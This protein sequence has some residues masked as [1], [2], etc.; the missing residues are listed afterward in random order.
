MAWKSS[1]PAARGKVIVGY[2]SIG[3]PRWRSAQKP[4]D[5]LMEQV[6][7]DPSGCH[8]WTGHTNQAGYGAVSINGQR[9]YAHRLAYEL[10]VGP[11]PE[12]LHID[13]TCHTN[14]ESCL[15]GPSCPHRACVNP[16]HLE[17]VTPAENTRRGAPARRTHCPQGHEYTPDNTQR[18]ARKGGKR[19]CKTCNRERSRATLA[20]RTHCYN[21]HE[22]TPD[23]LMIRSDGVRWCRTCRKAFADA[24]R[25]E[26]NGS[27]RLTP[28]QRDEIVRRARAG[29]VHA[30]IAADYGVSR[31]AVSR[32]KRLADRGAAP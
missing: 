2:D 3:R 29:E 21:G 13:H 32:L 20:N 5:K 6:R 19:E 31:P 4:L 23:N 14:D 8:V 10:L 26:R 16:D 22:L 30:R 27:A 15:G 12:G 25:G 11:V 18:R 28:A 1:D 9:Y 24:Q 17:P 7:V